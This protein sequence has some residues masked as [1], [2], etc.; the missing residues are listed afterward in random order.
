MGNIQENLEVFVVIRVDSASG[1]STITVTGFIKDIRMGGHV[2]RMVAAEASE[3]AQD[4]VPVPLVG[5]GVLKTIVEKGINSFLVD[6]IT[7][8]V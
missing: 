8:A 6:K 4:N 1:N 7:I 2:Q 5:K 3:I